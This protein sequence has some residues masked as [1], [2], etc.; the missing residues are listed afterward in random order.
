MRIIGFNFTKLSVDRTETPQPTEKVDIETT[1][2]ITSVSEVKD[3]PIKTE[4]KAISVD[5]QYGVDYKPNFAKVDIKGRLVLMVDSKIA[6]EV[7]KNWEKKEVPED[8][9]MFLFNIVLKKSTLKALQLEEEL[10]LPLHIP[11]PSFRKSEKK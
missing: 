11:M 8:F 7:L 3:H 9:R 6:K 5:F 10:N 1:M 2:D 4:D